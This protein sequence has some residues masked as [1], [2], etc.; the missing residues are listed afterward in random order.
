MTNI[1]K[2]F[3]LDEKEALHP[4]KAGVVSASVKVTKIKSNYI[5][6]NEVVRF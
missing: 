3:D 6:K 2:M 5:F 4:S 1:L